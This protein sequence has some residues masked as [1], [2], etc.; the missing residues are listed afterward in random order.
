[1]ACAGQ[2]GGVGRVAVQLD[3]LVVTDARALVQAVDVLGD[4]GLEQ[5]HLLQ[6]RQGHMGRIGPGLGDPLVECHPASPVLLAQV[7]S[8]GCKGVVR[9]SRPRGRH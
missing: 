9:P 3:D 1:M 5:A 7:T 4:H 2:A 8:I 6:L